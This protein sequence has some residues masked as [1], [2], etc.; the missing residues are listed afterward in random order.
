MVFLKAEQRVGGVTWYG[1]ALPT[2]APTKEKL[3]SF[4][5]LS[6]LSDLERRSLLSFSHS[7]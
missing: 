7:A 5:K 1:M 6:I 3:G 2:F 4:C